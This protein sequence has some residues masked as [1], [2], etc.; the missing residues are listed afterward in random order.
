MPLTGKVNITSKRLA[1]INPAPYNPR[2]MTEKQR[3]GLEHSIDI[4]GLVEPI[5]WNKT[6]NH[7]VGGHQRFFKL[8][9]DGIVETDV[10]VVELDEK[11][12]KALNI[13]LNH[14]GI[15]G[16]FE[17]EGLGL[18]LQEIESEDYFEKLNLEELV[19]PE[20]DDLPDVEGELRL[21]E[22]KLKI[23]IEIPREKEHLKNELVEFILH[24]IEEHWPGH[25]I[26][27]K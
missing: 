18:L 5:V 4:F 1:D 10:V 15:A 26:T 3:E 20:W 22:Q 24:A 9:K 6:T 23:I 13:A 17:M 19:E 2:Y 16:E 21:D 7:I 27:A 14:R 12:E 8:Q 11:K 25:G